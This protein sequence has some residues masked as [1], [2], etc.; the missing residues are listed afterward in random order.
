MSVR[1]RGF[2]LVELLVVIAIIGI[3]IA[4]LLPAVAAAREAARRTQCRNNLKQLGLAL[5]NYHDIHKVF[6]PFSVW[7]GAGGEPLGGGTLPVG[8]IDHVAQGASPGTHPDPLQANWLILLLPQLGQTPL[9]L[10]F[11]S[12]KPI[13]DAVNAPIRTAELSMFKCPS[14]ANFNSRPHDRLSLPGGSGNLHARGNYG[15]NLGVNRNCYFWPPAAG[16]CEDGFETGD[17]DLLNKNL[18]TRGNGIGGVNVSRDLDDF[19]NGASNMVAVE[20]LRAGVHTVDNR[21]TWALGLPGASGTVSHGYYS[22]V[23]D[24]NG[25]NHRDPQADDIIGCT[26]LRAVISNLDDMNMPCYQSSNPLEEI[27][28]QATSR[29][30]HPGGVMVMMLDGSGHFV[31]DNVSADVWLYMH[32]RDH[33]EGF[34]LPF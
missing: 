27:N 1:R 7:G 13:S 9:Y 10:Q 16:T 22:S 14:D 18:I 32:K 2:T 26:Q 11:D 17:S 31:S 3:L 28:I 29:S 4:L 12:Q 19:Q 33:K 21:G 15:M 6:P 23:D 5:H 25:P 24:D 34:E 30:R 8:F 20:E